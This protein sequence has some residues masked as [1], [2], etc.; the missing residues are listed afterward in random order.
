[1]MFINNCVGDVL[2]TIACRFGELGLPLGASM[3]T[4]AFLFEI[5]VFKIIS[6]ACTLT[7]SGSIFDLVKYCY[8]T[9]AALFVDICAVLMLFAV[10]ICYTI[11]ASS[12]IHE[13]Y[14]WIMK[15]SC[16]DIE[17]E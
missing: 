13:A 8:N 9:R 15:I 4:A 11:I 12:Y 10:M 16:I 6:K 3:L 17:C 1:M 14:N 5:W 7:D 2:L